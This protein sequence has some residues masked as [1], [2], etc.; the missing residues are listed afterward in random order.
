MVAA[1]ANRLEHET[2]AISGEDMFIVMLAL[3][4]ATQSI[5]FRSLYGS[6][7]HDRTKAIL[8]NLQPHTK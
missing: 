3:G 4:H 6:Y 1:A 5:E 7:C 8:I 2:L